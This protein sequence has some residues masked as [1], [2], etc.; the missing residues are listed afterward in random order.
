[1]VSIPPVGTITPPIVSV[2]IANYNGEQLLLDCIDSVLLQQSKVEIEILVH[3]DAS[4][5]GSLALL[6][7]RFPEVRILVSPENV[8]FCIA[9]NRMVDAARGEYVL[10]L[11][12]DAALFPDTIETLLAHARGRQ[13]QGI[14]SVPQYDWE[15][16][17]L[18]DFGCMLDPFYNPIPNTDPERA[19]VA[20]V[21]GACLF[22]PRAL[23][24]QLGGFPEWMES[25]AED[26]Y[27]CCL[28]RLCGYPVQ[29]TKG[30]GYR[31][32]QGTSFG[33][34]RGGPNGLET[35][36]RR[37]RLSERN[38]TLVMLVFSPTALLWILLPVHVLLLTFEGIIFGVAKRDWRL[39]RDI[40][41]AALKSLLQLGKPTLEI[42]RKVQE[43]RHVDWGSFFR[44][45]RLSPRK[46]TLL[47]LHGLPTIRR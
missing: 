21:I 35:T 16:G 45:F 46:H 5:D 17:A 42:R 22:I 41:G 28:A 11:N 14:L 18:V 3:D 20:Y 10:L 2:C 31:H 39:A 29:V 13:P 25:I 40:Y 33:G 37:R 32:R 24:H 1:M 43:S 12:N 8:G 7:A 38:K 30:G 36:I 19:D 6:R 34:N 4:S 47:L 9:N 44:A 26:M 15:S 23:W 27:L